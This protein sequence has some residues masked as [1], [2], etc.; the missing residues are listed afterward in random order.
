MNDKILDY[1]KTRV[2]QIAILMLM[3]SGLSTA[4]ASG[5]EV[6][7]M[8][9]IGFMIFFTGMYFWITQDTGFKFSIKQTRKKNES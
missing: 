6:S 7:I 9:L 1:Y 2:V 5:N 8:G 4:T 3:L